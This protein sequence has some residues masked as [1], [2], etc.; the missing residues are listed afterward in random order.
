M[1][2]PLSIGIPTETGQKGAESF[3]E[4]SY[5]VEFCNSLLLKVLT[6]IALLQLQL[7]VSHLSALQ[8]EHTP[9]EERAARCMRMQWFKDT[10]CKGSLKEPLRL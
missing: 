7:G 9:M 8:P 1:G 6:L 10:S 5:S 4:V 2:T 3:S